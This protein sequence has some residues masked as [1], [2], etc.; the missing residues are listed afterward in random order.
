MEHVLEDMQNQICLV[1]LDDII[2]YNWIFEG[3]LEG[4]HKATCDKIE[5]KS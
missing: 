2:I 3:M 5:G 4:F 1:Y